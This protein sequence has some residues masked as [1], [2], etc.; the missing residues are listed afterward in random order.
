MSAVSVI[1]L[2]EL[3]MGSHVRVGEGDL[4]AVREALGDDFGSASGDPAYL[5]GV[6][7][8]LASGQAPAYIEDDLEFTVQQLLE[9]IPEL[10]AGREFRVGFSEA[11]GSVGFTPT[12]AIITLRADYFR[13]FVVPRAELLAAM[14]DCCIRFVGFVRSA[15][16]GDTDTLSRIELLD[17]WVEQA[18]AA[19]S[20]PS[21]GISAPNSAR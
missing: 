11:P 21:G 14:L 6:V 4:D 13:P 18:R 19:L 5:N 16:A 17:P 15:F 3:D 2:F 20:G 12:E 8:F 1:V 9:A 10:V 7:N